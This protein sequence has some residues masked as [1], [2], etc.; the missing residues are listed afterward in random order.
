MKS[1]GEQ[2]RQ[3]DSLGKTIFI[4]QV[5]PSIRFAS[6]LR[7]VRSKLQ[8]RGIPRSRTCGR[9]SEF[10]DSRITEPKTRS[11]SSNRFG[12]DAE[13]RY[14]DRGSMRIARQELTLSTLAFPLNGPQNRSHQSRG[15]HAGRTRNPRDTVRARRPVAR[16]CGTTALRMRRLCSAARWTSSIW[17]TSSLGR[18]GR[19]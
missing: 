1:T 10:L 4:R 16:Y 9:A 17:T 13:F 19:N 18:P 6:N 2:N 11:G 14:T 15:P 5:F 8:I 7:R 12:V 3:R